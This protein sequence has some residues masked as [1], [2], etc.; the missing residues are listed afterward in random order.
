MDAEVRKP[1]I[2]TFTNNG[3][4]YAWIVVAKPFSS[5][6]PGQKLRVL[7]AYE[8]AVGVHKE[9]ILDY[10]I[11]DE[12]I[13]CGRA[14]DRAKAAMARADVPKISYVKCRC[15]VCQRYSNPVDTRRR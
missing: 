10:I 8:R 1:E 15:A 13:H 7:W 11:Q 9:A 2:E 12:A 4:H 14:I 5:L 3:Y 6:R